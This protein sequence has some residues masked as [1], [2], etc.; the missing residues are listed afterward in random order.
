MDLT[1]ALAAIKAGKLDAQEDP[2][3]NA[4]TYGV[5]AFHRFHTETNH[6]H[7]AANLRPSPLDGR[8]AEANPG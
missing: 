1:E 4:V 2:F 7:L 8:M 6:F 3:S 5:H